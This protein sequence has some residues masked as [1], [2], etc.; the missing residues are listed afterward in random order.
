MDNISYFDTYEKNLCS[1]CRACEQTCKKN[2]IS[3][4]FDDEGFLYPQI[5][6]DLCVECNACK[7]VCPMPKKR[8]EAKIIKIYE[9]QNR[10]EESL[11]R[12]SSGGVFISLAK[13]VLNNNGVVF[14]TVLDDDNNAII[15]AADTEAELEK[16]QGSKYVSSNTLSTYSE[17]EGYLKDGKIVL[18]TGAPCQ[19]AGLKCFL[20]KD[21]ENLIT[22]DFLCHGMPSSK[23]F[24]EN[25]DF[26]AKKY[27]GAVSEYKF[28][29]KSLK[30][31]GHV[32]SYFVNRK[33]HYEPG[34][35]NAYFYGFIKGYLNR[36]SCYS[37]PFRGEK[38]YSDIT[39]GDFWGC[40]VTDLNLRKGVS[41]AALNT[42]VGVSVFE[43][44]KNEFLYKETVP[45]KVAKMN[46][47][48]LSSE[49]EHIPEVRKNI[50]KELAAEGYERVMH[51]YLITD[52]RFLFKAKMKLDIILRKLSIRK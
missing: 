49:S 13:Y 50:Y 16:M 26:L 33:K 4:I 43:K 8:D 39:V 35:L 2:A 14:G 37:C 18:F 40:D 11:K 12:S 1:G 29:D 52:K 17:V 45:E 42:A 27:K 36:Y 15:V 31:W 28:R 47:S 22:M 46:S 19:V 30:G 38:R 34:K 3:M 6:E 23:I 9:L 5:N 10:N 32:T 41:F 20:K 51:K 24:K 48:L 44:I 7:N 25:I 21:F